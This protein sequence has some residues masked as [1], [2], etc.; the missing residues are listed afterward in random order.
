MVS[1][2][3][4]VSL[5]THHPTGTAR[6][7]IS[8]RLDQGEREGLINRIMSQKTLLH[9][10]DQIVRALQLTGNEDCGAKES[11]KKT[12]NSEWEVSLV[13]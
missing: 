5:N 13:Q 3:P 4:E 8:I 11:I 6:V 9:S 12:E 7:T 1:E 2:S 10:R